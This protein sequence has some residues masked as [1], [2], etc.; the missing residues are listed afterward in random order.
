[1]DGLSIGKI[2][3]AANVSADTVR[4]YERI[5]LIS[6]RRAPSQAIARTRKPI[7]GGSFSFA[8]RARLAFR[9]KRS[10]SS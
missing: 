10:P 3:R 6:A 5:G 7:C 9:L 4:Y 8:G 2:A 1:M